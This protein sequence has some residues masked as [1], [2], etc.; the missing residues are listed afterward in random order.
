MNHPFFA[1]FAMCLAWFASTSNGEDVSIPHLQKDN[2]TFKLMVDGK[3]FLILGGELGNSAP[4][5]LHY[6]E[7]VWPVLKKIHLNTVLAPVYWELI[8]PKENQFDFTLLDGLIDQARKNDMHLVLLW[9]GGGPDEYT[10]VG[11]GI[12]ITHASAKEAE[13]VGLLT[14]EEW[15]ERDGTWSCMCMLNGDETNQGRHVRLSLVEIGMQRV[16]L[17]RYH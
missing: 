14:V 3:P 16:K 10:V 2:G 4:S 17:Y 8:E 1:L 5:S 9:F 12:T 6:M 13:L 7:Q 15:T 11:Q